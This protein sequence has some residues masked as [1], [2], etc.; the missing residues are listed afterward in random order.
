[1]KNLFCT[2]VS[3][4][5]VGSVA[6][7]EGKTTLGDQNNE[8]AAPAKKEIIKTGYNFGPLP[9]VAFDADKAVVLRGFVLH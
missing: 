3:L 2:I 6:A 4:L 9:A 8:T 1:M 5:L 7:H